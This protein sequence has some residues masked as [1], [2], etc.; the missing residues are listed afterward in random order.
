MPVHCSTFWKN[1]TLHMRT[2]LRSC[3]YPQF[4][5]VTGLMS[6][7]SPRPTAFKDQT[8][9]SH[10]TRHQ[11]CSTTPQQHRMTRPLTPHPRPLK[12]VSL[13][14]SGCWCWGCYRCW[15]AVLGC[16]CCCW[17]CGAE[18]A[19]PYTAYT[20]YTVYTAYTT[21]APCTMYTSYTAYTSYT[22][23]TAYTAYLA[24]T[25]HTAHTTY[26]AYTSY[27]AYRAPPWGS[28]PALSL[29]KENHFPEKHPQMGFSLQKC[30]YCPFWGF[31]G[32]LVPSTGWY[33]RIHGQ[34]SQMHYCGGRA[35]SG[36]H[37]PVALSPQR[38]GYQPSPSR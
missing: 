38:D 15:G 24:Y 37:Q 10:D 22:P 29:M 1:D 2:H 4:P 33:C 35:I 21:H 3:A 18:N 32:F 7:P 34:S 12:S 36:I 14:C 27:T 28:V 8:P 5:D 20:T 9:D 31:R 25:A 13:S 16:W 17:N 6:R 11:L 26:T 30:T 19:Y 23:Y